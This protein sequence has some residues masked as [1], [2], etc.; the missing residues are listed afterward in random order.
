MGE[1]QVSGAD[2]ERFKIIRLDDYSDA[3]EGQL[4]AADTVAG[5]VSYKDKTG[6]ACSKTFGPHAIKIVPKR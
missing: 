4:V 5:V 6:T 2:A 3:I 1:T